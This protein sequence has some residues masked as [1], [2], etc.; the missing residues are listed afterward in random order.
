VFFACT[1]C[2]VSTI[3][4]LVVRVV[5]HVCFLYARC[6]DGYFGLTADDPLGCVACFCYGHSS[7]CTA[8]TDYAVDVIRSDFT[9]G[10]RRVYTEVRVCIP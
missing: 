8:S 4:L 2:H 6:K 9:T 5:V 1:N 10:A 7:N 3:L